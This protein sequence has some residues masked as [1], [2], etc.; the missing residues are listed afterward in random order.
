[1]VMLSHSCT[2]PGG[3][4]A[5]GDWAGSETMP[6][7]GP[8][9]LY[10]WHAVSLP[11]LSPED[12]KL[13][14]S[15]TVLSRISGEEMSFLWDVLLTPLHCQGLIRKGLQGIPGERKA[16][17]HGRSKSYRPGTGGTPVLL[18]R[19]SVWFGGGC[20]IH[21]SVCQYTKGHLDLFA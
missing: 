10:P 19:P 1:M 15:R 7:S 18:G 6:G 17:H 11:Q 5:G 4:G 20:H 8:R 9:A 14:L 13:K 12:G 2:A 16:I 21:P 3:G